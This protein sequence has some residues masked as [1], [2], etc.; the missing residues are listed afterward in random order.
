MSG[1]I[2]AGKD[3]LSADE[4]TKYNAYHCGLCRALR[5]AG[6]VKAKAL[7]SY[8]MTYIYILLSSIYENEPVRVPFNCA[9]HPL[10]RHTC[11]SGDIA[12]YT[13]DMTILLS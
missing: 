11:F 8:D 13:A 4:I 6:G 12:R 1:I 7:L 9:F 10:S 2:I 5:E 3:R